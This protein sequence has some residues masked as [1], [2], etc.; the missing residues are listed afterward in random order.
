MNEGSHGLLEQ[1]LDRLEER[2]RAVLTVAARDAAWREAIHMAA[3][4]SIVVPVLWWIL[5]FFRP[6]PIRFV[7]LSAILAPLA[8]LAMVFA[9]RMARHRVA[10]RE[11]LALVDRLLA[12]KDRSVI[13]AEFLSSGASDGFRQAA[14]QEAAPWLDRAVSTPVVEIDGERGPRRYPW[15]FPL[16]ALVVLMLLLL[17]Q[18]VPPVGEGADRR[19]ALAQ[20]A[21]AWGARPSGKDDSDRGD[22]GADRQGAGSGAGASMGARAGMA[23]SEQ[24]GLAGEAGSVGSAMGGNDL[25]RSSTAGQGSG[26]SPSAAAGG[27]PGADAGAARDAQ[28]QSPRDASDGQQGVEQ[29]GGADAASTAGETRATAPRGAQG[30]AAALSSPTGSPPPHAP[31]GDQDRQGSGTRQRQSSGDRSQGS[32]SSG[33]ASNN[34]QQGSNR[35]D[36]QEGT[37]RARGSSSLLLA[38]PMEDRVIGTVN[39]GS[40]STTTR[41]AP[42][43]AMAAGMVAAG[44]RG[45]G[46]G[47]AAQLP[48]RARSVQEDRLLEAYFRRAGVEP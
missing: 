43:R 35:G 33:R 28:V 16:A 22:V 32:G 15:G 6:V 41:N 45:A 11:A 23:A 3:R 2:G 27:A 29:G 10:R 37:K 13:A 14:L 46:Q 24:A 39:A 17:V 48:Q 1:R 9:R 40:V 34:G 36:G 8:V 25:P 44:S 30:G 38:V 47:P 42:P 21:A 12:L 31:G 18:R 19:S 4:G 5:A 26:S 7:I 20:I